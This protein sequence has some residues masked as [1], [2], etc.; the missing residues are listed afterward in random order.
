V[1]ER[2]RV[3]SADDDAF[4]A[5]WEAEAPPGHTLHR[6]LRAD[7]PHRFVSLPDGPRHGALLITDATADLDRLPGRQGFIRARVFGEL[8]AVEWSSPL[9]YQRAVQAG[10]A[11]PGT[12]YGNE[13]GAPP[14]G[15]G[16]P[17]SW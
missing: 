13:S 9:M 6:A 17:R 16:A 7:A 15:E 8:A 14:P 4:R 5:A 3:P 1:I 11:L 2:F 10:L 12:L